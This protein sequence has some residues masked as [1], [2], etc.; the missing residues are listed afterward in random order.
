MSEQQ[1]TI[2]QAIDLAVQHHNAGR[3]PEAERLYQQI[4]QADPEQPVALHLLGVIAHQ[5]GK[6]DIAVDLITKALGLKPDYVEAYGNL[7]SVLLDQGKFDRALASAKKAI[8]LNPDYAAGHNNMGFAL[9]ELGRSE[10]AVISCRK[11]IAISPA[12]PDGHYNLG[13]A[14]QKIGRLDE[15]VAS[16]QKTI[17]IKSDHAKA[18]NNLGNAYKEL[19]RTDE[20]VASYRKAINNKPDYATAYSNLGLALQVVGK[21]AESISF[22]QR[23][24]TLEPE[25][26]FFWTGF[27]QSLEKFSFTSIDD[28][29]Y[30]DLLR[31]LKRP[32]V[33]PSYVVR[34]IISALRCLPR[35][36]RI[37]ERADPRTSESKMA[38]GDF[39]EQLSLLPLFLQI[40]RLNPIYDLEIERMLTLLRHAMLEDAIAGNHEANEMSLSAAIALHCSINEFVFFESEEE[41]IEVR[42]LEYQVAAMVKEGRDVSPLSVAALG[43][44][45]P[46][47]GF[48]WAQKLSERAW[49]GDIKEVIE[50]QILEPQEELALRSQIAQLTPIQDNVSL[51]VRDQYEE[52]PYPRWTKTGTE[53]NRRPMET[54]LRSSPLGFDLGDYKAPERPEILVAG[55][56]TGQ[57]AIITESRFLNSNMLAVDLSMRS[58]SYALRK[59]N[60]LGITNIEYAQADIMELGGLE[61]R[62]DLIES[63]GVLHHLDEPLAGW[64]VLVEL[65]KPGGLMRI[66]L[67][68]DSAR[69]HI[70]NGRAQMA[71]K[72]YTTSPEDIRRCRRD[73]VTMAEAGNSTM[74]KICGGRDFFNLSN[75][76]DLL[77]HVKEHRFTL[78]Q[79][80]QALEALNLR[81]LGFELRDQSVLESFKES[82]PTGR[83]L[84]SLSQWHLFELKYPDTFPGMYQFWCQKM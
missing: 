41:T 72:S 40:M 49:V 27:A 84:T 65:V 34:S 10:E 6:S 70:V 13:I 17:S 68:S 59:T 16:Y 50:R 79:I 71:K 2:Q 31:L 83:A 82:V 64:R 33:R 74:A 44:Y 63:V 53:A 43:A 67:Y 4:L 29:L 3:L 19:E 69:Q 26:E 14:L 22:H 7:G 80:S 78:P 45:R 18:H 73:I 20:A 11:A 23:A 61:R 24:I 25:N 81:F 9:N 30:Q 39:A 36:A 35:F 46:L 54:V 32:S 42:K 21:A 52:N 60:Q 66:G 56:G 62:F 8:A 51:A 58:L 47:Y 12:H 55:C 75:C 76:R 38:F 57:H 37:L 48:P 77:F 28:I 15:A 1:Q 5:V